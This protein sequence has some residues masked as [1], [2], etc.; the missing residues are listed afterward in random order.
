MK[1]PY[2]LYLVLLLNM[3]LSQSLATKDHVDKESETKDDVDQNA[4]GVEIIEVTEQWAKE[5]GLMDLYQTDPGFVK[6]CILFH[7]IPGNPPYSFQQKRLSQ[8]LPDRYYSCQA[9]LSSDAILESK[10]C[11]MPTCLMVSAR[12][13]LPGEKLTIRLSTKDAFRE[14]TFYPRPL[15][16]KK[17]TGEFLAQATLLCMQPG[18]TLYELDICGIGK[19]E[20]F[21]LTSHS[22]KEIISYN[23]QGPTTCS[24]TPE[25]IG[26]M[27]GSANVTIHFE[28]GA[29]YNVE[30]PW[31]CELLKY[32]LGSK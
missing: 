25:V 19:Q 1:F 28:N 15:L 10:N 21:K 32:K 24:I 3:N 27:T 20:K 13:Y 9:G 26:Q 22:G 4:T 30:L 16:L 6:W 31:G 11:N 14:I 5:R 2:A 23:W 18:S 8:P 7:D 29:Q 17:E 12:G